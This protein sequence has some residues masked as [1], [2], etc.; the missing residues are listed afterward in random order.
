MFQRLGAELQ[1]QTMLRIHALGFARRDAEELRVEVVGI[2]HEAAMTAVGLARLVR[3]HAE[4]CAAVPTARR[5]IADGAFAGRENFPEPVQADDTV[6]KTY[7]HADYRRGSGWNAC[8]SARRA[9]RR[10][11]SSNACLTGLSAA[12]GAISDIEVLEFT[13][14][15]CLCVRL[16]HRRNHRRVV[17]RFGRI[18][19]AG[20]VFGQQMIAQRIERWIIKQHCRRQM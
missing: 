2:A 7:S 16:R 19:F 12:G 17:R 5:H 18:W 4:Q 10:R 3:I 14:Q 9:R 1:Q 15:H 6:G 11:I 13:P 8:T 20:K